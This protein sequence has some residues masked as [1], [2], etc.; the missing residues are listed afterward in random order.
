MS[1]VIHPF[2][3]GQPQGPDTQQDVIAELERLLAEAKDGN[4]V[5]IAV[6]AVKVE[7]NTS[8]SYV[9]DGWCHRVTLAVDILHHRLLDKLLRDGYQP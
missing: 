4:V 6:A 7:G 8:T 2:P 1:A 3:Y 5:A 9:V